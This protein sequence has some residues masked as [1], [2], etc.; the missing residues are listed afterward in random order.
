[1]RKETQEFPKHDPNNGVIGDCLRAALASLL[2]LPLQQVP[3]FLKEHWGNVQATE[4]ALNRFLS[5][6]GLMMLPLPYAAFSQLL[7]AQAQS[8][9]SD[10]YHLIFGVDHEGDRH[11][12][13]GRN[14]QIVHD[15]HPLKRGF[16]NPPGEWQIGLMV[17]RFDSQPADQSYEDA[18][19]IEH[20][21]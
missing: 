16:A 18:W 7:K 11:A 14:G 9:G 8:T 17:D 5:K 4:D 19:K 21:L 20:R 13:V 6:R 3:H 12:C 15:P 1:M 2:G 10:C